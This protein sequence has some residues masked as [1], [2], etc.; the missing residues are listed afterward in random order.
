MVYNIITAVL[1]VLVG[2]ALAF[3]YYKVTSPPERPKIK[4]PLIGRLYIYEGTERDRYSFAF[5]CPLEQIGQYRF[6]TLLI[7]RPQNEKT[8]DDIENAWLADN[9]ETNMDNE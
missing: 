7:E 4:R 3:L 5:D 6:A 9:S 2:L 1:G 8:V